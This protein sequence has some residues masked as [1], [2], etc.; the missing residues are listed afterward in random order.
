MNRYP[1]KRTFGCGFDTIQEEE[2]IF[3]IILEDD[4]EIIKTLLKI[5]SKEQEARIKRDEVELTKSK[6]ISDII[7]EELDIKGL[8]E[9]IISS[10]RYRRSEDTWSY[11]NLL[12]KLG[13]GD[14]N[15][16]YQSHYG[17]S[18]TIHLD[19]ERI[20]AFLHGLEFNKEVKSK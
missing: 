16:I 7:N 3:G 18:Y 10:R 8:L 15:Y 11:T 1:R 5:E 14:L 4:F 9:R 13:L 20:S 12:Y 19:I 2:S 6:E 17:D